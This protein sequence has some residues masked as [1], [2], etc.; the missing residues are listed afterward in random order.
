MLIACNPIETL[1]LPQPTQMAT[2]T[3]EV[4][5]TPTA[6]SPTQQDLLGMQTFDQGQDAHF[7]N[8]DIDLEKINGMNAECKEGKLHFFVRGGK[9][10]GLRRMQMSVPIEQASDFNIEMDA[11]SATG[12]PDKADQNQY[13]LI[14]PTDEKRG[15]FLRFKGQFFIFQKYL[16]TKNSVTVEKEIHVAE[17][18]NWNY[19]PY[20]QPAGKS[21]HIQF[22][23]LAGYCDL[24]VNDNLISRIQAV[25]SIS[26]SAAGLFAQVDSEKVFGSVD[27]DNL[28]IYQTAKDTHLANAYI[29]K[30]DLRSDKGEFMDIGMSGAYHG[31]KADGFHFSPVI[32][33]GYYGAKTGPALEDM[34]VKVTAKLN[35]AYAS[36]STY[37]GVVCRSSRE[38][39][40]I[41]VIRDNGYYSIFR[42]TPNRTFSLLAE[43]FT[44]AIRSG[45]A[46]NKLRLDCIGQTIAFYVNDQKVA[47]LVD[48][49]FSIESGRAGIFTKGGKSPHMDAIIFSDLEINEVR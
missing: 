32:S 24:Y 33:F 22:T 35:P 20:I 19:S 31:Y 37:A 25:Q 40:Y 38:G 7:C 1:P 28:H 5:P 21:N 47:G 29:L 4:L 46:A 2:S 49:R 8:Q 44:S 9:T 48:S 16:I 41:A 18:W 43:A 45:G 42:D 12:E 11:I 30:D 14:L 39:M 26:I 36:A 3:A 6:H 10:I 34:S 27:V 13:G 15:Y 23:C 17:D